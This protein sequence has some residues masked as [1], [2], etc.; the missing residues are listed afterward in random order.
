MRAVFDLAGDQRCAEEQ[1]HQ[2]R[3][4]HEEDADE[5]QIL[6]LVLELRTEGVTAVHGLVRGQHVRAQ[7]RKARAQAGVVEGIVHPQ[8][9]GNHDRGECGQPDPGEERLLAMLFPRQPDHAVTS[10]TV[11]AARVSPVWR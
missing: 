3:Q 11:R 6:E 7:L 5:R 4:D 1:P 9:G 10:E 8:T 2:Q